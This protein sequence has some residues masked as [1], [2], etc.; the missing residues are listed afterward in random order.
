M[1]NQ[2]A[3][4]APPPPTPPGPPV[5]PAKKGC[6]VATTLGCFNDDPTGGGAAVLP[7]SRPENHDRL[8]LENCA[9]L[10]AGSNLPVAGIDGGNHCFC[11]TAVDATT[12]AALA[13]VRPMSECL[14]KDCPMQPRDG[15]SC[16][17]ASSTEKC[18]ALHRL[19]VY[20]FTSCE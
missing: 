3:P 7:T 19:L 17:G 5:P 14:V 4:P 16:S 20:N 18:G 6:K 11:G 1:L 15:C 10:C 8:T 13:A 9:G 2:P 12:P